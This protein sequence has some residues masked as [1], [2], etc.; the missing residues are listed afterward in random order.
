MKLLDWADHLGAGRPH[1]SA[2]DQQPWGAGESVT[3][4]S[5]QVITV[6]RHIDWDPEPVWDRE[7][8]GPVHEST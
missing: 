8:L 4:V 1:K 3:S 7:A 6:S 5:S 2:R